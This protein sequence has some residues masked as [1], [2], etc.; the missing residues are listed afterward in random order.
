MEFIRQHEFLLKLSQ[1]A[2][3]WL[4]ISQ[5]HMEQ[6]PTWKPEKERRDCILDLWLQSTVKGRHEESLFPC[7]WPFGFAAIVHYH[8]SKAGQ[9]LLFPAFQTE[10]NSPNFGEADDKL[11]NI[12]NSPCQPSP[13]PESSH[14][15]SSTKLSLLQ[16]FPQPAPLQRKK[17]KPFFS[18]LMQ[19]TASF[20][21]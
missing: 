15:I 11:F 2:H 16:C 19:L 12:M 17:P 7:S 3:Y 14:K 18:S 5:T 9:S 8:Q 4:C 6:N 20:F 10:Q 13:L 21:A 1:N